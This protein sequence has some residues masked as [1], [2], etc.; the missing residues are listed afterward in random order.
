M[1]ASLLARL[2]P[3]QLAALPAGQPLPGVQSNFDHPDSIAPRAIAVI[4]VF[5]AI[6]IM[7]VGLRF[8]SR[9]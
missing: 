5:L 2:T 3:E 9:I 7:V 4:S 8:Y 1:D 6:M